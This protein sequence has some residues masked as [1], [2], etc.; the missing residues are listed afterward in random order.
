M[1]DRNKTTP[2][3]YHHMLKRLLPLPIVRRS[4]KLRI[5]CEEISSQ[6]ERILPNEVTD[7]VYIGSQHEGL[8]V[9]ITSIDVGD[10]F[11]SK[12][13]YDAM[14]VLRRY[15]VVDPSLPVITEECTAEIGSTKSTELVEI[16]EIREASHSEV[17]E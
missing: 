6:R 2:K 7:I 9:T 10:A 16:L 8:S 17:S 14:P 15:L 3:I 13:D 12:S 11:V 4:Y 5:Y 1:E